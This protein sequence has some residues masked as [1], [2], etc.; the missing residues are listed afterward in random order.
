MEF[1]IRDMSMGETFTAFVTE[2]GRV[3]WCGE[4]DLKIP[5]SEKPTYADGNTASTAK[6]VACDATAAGLLLLDTD[7]ME[8]RERE[9]EKIERTCNIANFC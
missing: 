4:E 2:C 8:R 9:R 6:I 1:K 7:G 5:R 3:F